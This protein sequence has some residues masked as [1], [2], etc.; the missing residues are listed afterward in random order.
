MH[1]IYRLEKLQS[2]LQ[3]AIHVTIEFPLIFHETF[4]VEVPKIHKIREI[5]SPQKG[6]L[7]YYICMQYEKKHTIII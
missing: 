1:D 6:T 3:S 7:Q 4:F 2:S 5:C